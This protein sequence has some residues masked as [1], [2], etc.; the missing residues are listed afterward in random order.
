MHALDA[1]L[2]APNPDATLETHGRE[3]AADVVVVL[4]DDALHVGDNHAADYLGA[5]AAGMQ[6][7]LLVRDPGLSVADH[8]IDSL[9][10]LIPWLQSCG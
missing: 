2:P 8:E 10:R 7:L 6:G 4:D 1:I 5:R 9:D 3:G